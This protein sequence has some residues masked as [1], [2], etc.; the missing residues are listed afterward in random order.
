MNNKIIKDGVLLLSA[1]FI[2]ILSSTIIAIFVARYYG[3]SI[4]GDYTTAVAFST[5]ILTFTDLG[6]DAYLL[7]EGSRDKSKIKKYYGNIL[8][9][10]IAILFISAIFI[11]VLA[12]Y[13]GYSQI[14]IKLILI[15]LPN[16]IISYVIST[17]FVIMQLLEKLNVNAKVQIIQSILIVAVAILVLVY[18]CN[19]YIYSILQSLISIVILVIYL[20]IIPVEFLFTT[21]HSK[22]LIK[23]S[24]LFGLSSL[25]FIVYYK[26]DTVMLSILVD[27]YAVGIYESAYKVVNILI[28]LIVILDNLVMPKFFKLYKEN[29]EKM[30]E[31]YRKLLEFAVVF[32]ISFSIMG[33]FMSREIINILYGKQYF[34]SIVILQILIWTVSIRLL[35][36]IVGFV[37]TASDNMNIKVR[38]QAI[39]AVFNIILNTILIPYYGVVG[40]SV[41]TV[42]TELMVFFTYYYYVRRKFNVNIKFKVIFKVICMNILFV[43]II[44]NINFNFNFIINGLLYV[45]IYIILLRIVFKDIFKVII[46]E[47]RKYRK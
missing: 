14:V 39:F 9:I 41:A 26:V 15:L 47:L 1:K 4:Y 43:C 21:K 46:G 23:G 42:I 35:A 37:I 24:I 28:S 44:I 33:M 25:L 30:F 3:V 12:K 19:I 20:K 11:V 34:D 6:L 40:A 16:C 27:T 22:N 7:K 18:G 8:L 13:L 45:L 5:F 31:I 2:G 36:A 17:F 38:F 10:K 32:G 29:K